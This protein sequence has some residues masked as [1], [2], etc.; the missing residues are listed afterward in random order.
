MS[1]ACLL[2][3]FFVSDDP[4]VIKTYIQP[5]K[6]PI[7]KIVFSSALTGKLYNSKETIIEEFRRS[8]LKPM[9]LLEVQNQNR[10][11]IEDSFLQFIQDQLAENKIAAFVEAL[12]EDET[13]APYVTKWVESDES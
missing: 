11:E 10:F 6:E 3:V 13:F 4:D 12:A 5:R 9:S 8:F 2:N 7:S 1:E